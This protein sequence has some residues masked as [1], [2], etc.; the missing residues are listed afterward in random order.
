MNIPSQE[1]YYWQLIHHLVVQLGV[2][3][4][5]V[6]SNE[7]EIWLEKE[8]TAE[9]TVLRILRRDMDWNNY[10]VRDLEQVVID[11]EKVRRELR[12]RRLN[13]VNIY[14]STFLPVDY[15]PITPHVSKNGKVTVR[16]FILHN[17]V[18]DEKEISKLNEVLECQVPNI[19]PTRFY[20]IEDIQIYRHQ[21]MSLSEKKLSRERA[22][23]SYGKPIFT[24]VLLVI[25]LVIYG[26][27]EYYGSS[28]S[29][30]TLVEFGAKYDPLINE[31]EWWRFF[32]AIFLHIGFLHLFMNS[33]A[34]FYLGSAVERIYGTSRYMI[35]YL[36]AGLFGSISS[37]A[38]NSQISA[39]ASG[40][41]FGCFGA[42]L[43]FGVVH[44]KL[45]FR[46][47]GKN[48]I[49]IL[50]VNLG[51]GLA[52]PM[53]DNSAHVGG[54]IGGF[55]A[56]AVLHLPK[57]RI[58]K[59]QFITL[60]VMAGAISGLLFYGFSTGEDTE[61]IHLINVQLSQELLQKGDIERAYPLLKAAVEKDLGMVEANFLLAY[62]EARLGLLKDAE[63]NL[64]ITLEQR[65][66]F[67]EAHFNL[68]LVYFEM[69]QFLDA[70][71][72]VEKA[73]E[74]KPDTEDYQNLKQTIEEI[75]QR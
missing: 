73:I 6:K 36:T 9:T 55:L 16:T 52:I 65:P 32:T 58:I 45:F 48:V 15:V 68:S 59:R 31:G 71:H 43:Y 35:I 27:M 49:V 19:D 5:K 64:L 33:L 40:A 26:L 42:L 66:E 44:K 51:L 17:E 60:I 13:I 56:S 29:L 21:I 37:F 30:L 7:R 20:T 57:H 28:T 46:T 4:F 25:V 50:I 34:L 41:I 10:I 62:S 2:T 67:H 54:L 38:F 61:K 3:A 23:F 63:K 12:S 53:I 39:G 70:Y 72:A 74:L 69:R 8:D 18:G 11:G 14:V 24:V 22:L 1:M 75:L 47:M